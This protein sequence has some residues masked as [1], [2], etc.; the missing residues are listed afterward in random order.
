MFTTACKRGLHVFLAGLVSNKTRNCKYSSLQPVALS[1]E[2]PLDGSHQLAAFF[3]GLL[4]QLLVLFVLGPRQDSGRI[5][6]TYMRR[7]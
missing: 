1:D 3:A 4:V 5:T 7:E 2:A 6:T